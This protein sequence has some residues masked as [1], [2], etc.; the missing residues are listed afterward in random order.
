MALEIRLKAFTKQREGWG[1]KE[2]VGKNRGLQSPVREVLLQKHRGLRQE[3]LDVP[4]FS[5]G[6]YPKCSGEAE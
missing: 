3:G 4:G 5:F 6:F 2:E 1:G